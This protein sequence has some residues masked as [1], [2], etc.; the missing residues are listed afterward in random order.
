MKRIRRPVS[1]LIASSLVWSAVGCYSGWDYANDSSRRIWTGMTM[2]EVRAELGD[3]DLVVRGDP[4]TETSWFYRYEEGASPI[5]WV[6]AFIFVVLLIVVL[7]AAAS[8]GGG[9]SFGGLGGGGGG[10]GPPVQIRVLFDAEGRVV[11]VS[12]PHPV[13]GR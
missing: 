6:V 7:V 8:G 9:G 1:I 11:E 4:G 5:V 13:S 3:P 10:D 2:G 12:E